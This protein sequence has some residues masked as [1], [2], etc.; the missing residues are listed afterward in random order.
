MLLYFFNI[1]TNTHNI[2][3]LKSV[4]VHI[5]T[6][7]TCPYMF[8][9]LF[10]IILKGARRLHFAKSL[11]WGLLINVCYKIVRFVAVCHFIPSV[12]VSG[13]CVCVCLSVCLVF[14]TE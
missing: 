13:V 2:Y 10:K 7:N 11:R 1:P 3:T 12:C 4:K 6:L 14:L 8:R 9:S 5:K